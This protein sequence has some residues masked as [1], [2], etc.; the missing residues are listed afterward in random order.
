MT[1]TLRTLVL[2]AIAGSVVALLAASGVVNAGSDAMTTVATEVLKGAISLVVISVAGALAKHAVDQ[3]LDDRREAGARAKAAE[4][5]RQG[6]REEF[7]SIFSEFYA[8]RKLYHSYLQDRSDLFGKG[9]E[10]SIPFR[11]QLLEK[12]VALEGRFGA[13]KVR[14][15]DYFN[16]SHAN[17]GTKQ[18]AEL[19]R[20][21]Q[22]DSD[23]EARFR[24]R[25]DLLGEYY[26]DWRHGIEKG[27]KLREAG[28]IYDEYE[29]ILNRLR[30]RP[31]GYQR[32]REEGH[33]RAKLPRPKDR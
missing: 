12:S 27:R 24:H 30:E 5:E 4:V 21:I 22:V 10:E 19:V 31:V 8:I 33:A 6:L 16:I 11:R 28:P 1:K 3:T 29:L 23:A 14:M 20:L 7:S 9:P 15:L 18:E 2:V 25:L 13:L 32:E 26:D 17:L